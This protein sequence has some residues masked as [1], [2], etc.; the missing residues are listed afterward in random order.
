MVADVTP[1]CSALEHTVFL[2]STESDE[3]LA[4]GDADVELPADRQFDD[5]RAPAPTREVSN[6]RHHAPESCGLDL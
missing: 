1:R 3:L 2:D 4:A 5:G 6:R